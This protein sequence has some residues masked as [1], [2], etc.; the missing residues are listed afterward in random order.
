MTRLSLVLLGGI[1]LAAAVW[2]L[3]GAGW[4]MLGGSLL[5]SVV[6][7]VAFALMGFN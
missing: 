1:T 4:A 2:W 7:G 6:Y 3:A 5:S